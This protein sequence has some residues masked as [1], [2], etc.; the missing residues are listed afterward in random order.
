MAKGPVLQ[1]EISCTQH[2]RH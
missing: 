2:G 1:N